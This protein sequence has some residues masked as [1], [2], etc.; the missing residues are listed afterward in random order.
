MLRTT[1][2]AVP[3]K[4]GQA[5][6]G[7]AVCSAGPPRETESATPPRGKY[8]FAETPDEIATA[9][10]EADA[11]RVTA[12]S[13]VARWWMLFTFVLVFIAGFMAVGLGSQILQIVGV[14]LIIPGGIIGWHLILAI[15][16][17]WPIP[18]KPDSVANE[19]RGQAAGLNEAPAL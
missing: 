7:P 13:D 11:N 18:G 16:I 17:N 15:C 10:R 12:A 14:S 19:P 6:V 5:P 8:A 2:A 9:T 1:S 3:P 4:T